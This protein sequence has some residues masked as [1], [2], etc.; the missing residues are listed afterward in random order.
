MQTSR[1]RTLVIALFLGVISLMGLAA[2]PAAAQPLAPQDRLCDPA[3]QDCRADILKYIEQE[4]VAIDMGFW[5]MTDARYANE[6]VKA[7]G[8]GVKIR[9][10]MDP[11]CGASHSACLVQNAQLAAAGIPMRNRLTSGIL[12][13]KVAIFAS[14]GQVQFAG[15]NYAPFEMSPE[16]PFVNYTDEIVYFTNTPSLVQSFMRKFDDLWTST[17][18]FADYANVAGPLARSYPLYSIDPELNFPPDQSYRTRALNAYAAEQ[19]S[20]DVLMFRIT[21]EQH[22][23]GMLAALARNV[24]VRLITDEEEYRNP[25]RLWDSYNVDKMYNAGVQVRLDGHLGINHEKAILLRGSGMTIFGSSSTQMV[26]LPPMLLLILRAGSC[27]SLMRSPG[28]A[29]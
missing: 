19:V 13:W 18:E 28:R 12:H 3:Y 17:T 27:R 6:L 11:R 15:A 9:L 29:A 14:Q 7:W 2:T 26:P 23:N 5:M 21:D 20:I 25:A 4:T 22:T 24:P 8:R 1:T 16:I 10:L